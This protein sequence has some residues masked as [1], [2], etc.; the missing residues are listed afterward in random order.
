M[1]NKYYILFILIIPLLALTAQDDKLVQMQNIDAFKKNISEVA[2]KTTS[3]Q[4]SFVQEKYLGILSESI[5]S[6]GKMLF[7]KPNL[8]K[9]SYTVPYE[10]T[11]VLNGKEVLIND[12]GNVNSFDMSSSKAFTEINDLIVSTVQGNVLQEKRFNI[13]YFQSDNRY[14]VKLLPKEA[15]F[16]KHIEEIHVFFDKNDYTVAQIRL[17]EAGGDYT[18]I[19]FFDKTMNAPVA[20]EEFQIR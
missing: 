19:N 11:I 18:L 3:I 4:T 15:H 17:N 8:L 5:E 16:K 6:K 12:E 10:Y 1:K 7:K 20:N 13:E 2:E 9:W 14:L